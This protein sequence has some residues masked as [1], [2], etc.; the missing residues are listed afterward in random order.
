M[1]P[2]AAIDGGRRVHEP[3]CLADLATLGAALAA[4][5]EQERELFCAA[6]VWPGPGRADLGLAELADKR[7]PSERRWT[8]YQIRKKL[9]AA[10]E[11]IEQE[12]SRRGIG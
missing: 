4:I 9:A 11:A 8:Q 6:V 7:W 2:R 10:R 1:I 12:L 3:A 5:P